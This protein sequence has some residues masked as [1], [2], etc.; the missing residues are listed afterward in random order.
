[1]KWMTH[2]KKAKELAHTLDLRTVS[3]E[4]EDSRCDYENGVIYIDASLPL[5]HRVYI[6]LHELGHYKV[7]SLEKEAGKA[8]QPHHFINVDTASNISLKTKVATI[9]E[10]ILAWDHA[11]TIAEMLEIP[12]DKGF[13]L[14][15]C[16]MLYSYFEWAVEQNKQDNDNN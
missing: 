6:F 15:R 16:K 5:K 12:L 14:L 13:T 7:H 8:Y 2:W 4:G 3:S 1:M 11:E 10:E 9:R